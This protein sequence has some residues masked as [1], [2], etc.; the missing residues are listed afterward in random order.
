MVGCSK[1]ALLLRRSSIVSSHAATKKEIATK[2]P[3]ELIKRSAGRSAAS[4]IAIDRESGHQTV[5]LV[6][7]VTFDGDVD[8]S[9][10]DDLRG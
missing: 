2:N 7:D 4:K 6:V 1:P 8:E 3:K 5:D 9:E 10:G